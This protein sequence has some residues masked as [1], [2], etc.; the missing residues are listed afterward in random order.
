MNPNKI[1]IIDDNQTV[2]CTLKLVL[3]SVFKTVVMR[4]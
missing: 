4:H 1:L 2:L 3:Y